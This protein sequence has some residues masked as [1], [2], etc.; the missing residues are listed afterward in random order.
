MLFGKLTNVKL[1]NDR[2][3]GREHEINRWTKHVII[4]KIRGNARR[5]GI[6]VTSEIIKDFQL[7]LEIYIREIDKV[8][9]AWLCYKAGGNSR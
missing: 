7:F 2:G 4:N 3:A 6:A 9:S 5:C 1:R 8:Y